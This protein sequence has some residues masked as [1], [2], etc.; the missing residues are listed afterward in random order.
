MCSVFILFSICKI[1]LYNS[2]SVYLNK[3]INTV[4]ILYFKRVLFLA[5]LFV[6]C[7]RVFIFPSLFPLS[8]EIVFKCTF[9]NISVT[10]LGLF[11]HLQLP[12]HEHWLTFYSIDTHFD[13][14]TL[15]SF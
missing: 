1:E 9:N 5:C 11:T 10:S 6:Y 15:D 8:N 4:S 12:T 2:P 3:S 14:S 13:A 7:A